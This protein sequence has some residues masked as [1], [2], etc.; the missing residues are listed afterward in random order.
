MWPSYLS[1]LCLGG[2][3]G[4][5]QIDELEVFSLDHHWRRTAAAEGLLH[6]RLLVE[7]VV[8]RGS[9]AGT[10]AGH[11]GGV[12]EPYHVARRGS[13]PSVH[14]AEPP[15]EPLLGPRNDAHRAPNRQCRLAH[16]VDGRRGD[17][18]LGALGR[19][20]SERGGGDIEGVGGGGEDGR[21]AL[22]VEVAQ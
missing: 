1:K 15:D 10:S 9:A 19:R 12:V 6:A 17:P 14:L 18:W 4:G 2:T 22:G 16:L 7:V 5:G 11:G 8:L 21:A 3:V 13:V 20:A